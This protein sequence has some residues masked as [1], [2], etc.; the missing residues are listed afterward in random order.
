MATEITL[1][2]NPRRQARITVGDGDNS[3]TWTFDAPGMSDKAWRQLIANGFGP[4]MQADRLRDEDRE[5]HDFRDRVAAVVATLNGAVE[6]LERNRVFDNSEESFIDFFRNLVTEDKKAGIPP[7]RINKYLATLSRFK[8]YLET[9]A[10]EGLR[11]SNISSDIM[12][13]F[14]DTMADEGLKPSTRAFYNRTLL[15]IYQRAVKAGLTP[16]NAPFAKV[17]TQ[18]RV[19]AGSKLPPK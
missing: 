16:D 3:L 15:A 13:D 11:P 18:Y 10:K 2:E 19:P 1:S 17:A 9:V 5:A 7:S 8:K 14:N 12:A 4:D 6:T